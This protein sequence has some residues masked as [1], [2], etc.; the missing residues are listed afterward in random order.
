MPL[1]SNLKDL[2]LVYCQG[3]L[4]YLQIGRM[5]VGQAQVYLA[6]AQVP[7]LV[8]VAPLSLPLV[9]SLLGLFC[10]LS[11]LPECGFA[12]S[13]CFFCLFASCGSAP[14]VVMVVVVCGLW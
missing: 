1:Q 4:E 13:C 12:C 6:V 8:L 10:S 11:S 14:G 3:D 9:L 5:R 7:F 2:S